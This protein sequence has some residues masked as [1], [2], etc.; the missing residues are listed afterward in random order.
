MAKQQPIYDARGE[1]ALMLELWDPHLAD[2]IHEFVR[3]VYPWGKPGTPLE[4]EKGPRNWQDKI[5][6]DMAEYIHKAKDHQQ[7]HKAVPAMY[8]AAIASGRGIGKSATFGWLAHWLVTTRIGGSV[9]V[10]ANGEP[11]LKTKTFPE[12]AKWVSMSINSHWFEIM[13]TKI[14][15][16][17]WLKSAVLRDLKIDA[18]YWYIA[19]Q[20]WSEE[21]PDAFA[22]AHN[23]Y[24]EMAL[25][26]E[27][28]GIPSPIWTVQQGVFTE[29]IVDRYWLAFSNPRRPS[30][31]FFECFHKNRDDW[32]GVQVDSRS[33]DIAQD[34]V[35]AIIKEHGEDSDEARIEVYGQFPS[36]GQNQFIGRSEVEMALARDIIADPGSPL[37]MG[38][39]VARF[40]EDTSV[41]AFRKGRDARTIPWHRYKGMS[42]TQLTGIVADLAGKMHV[43]AI[44]VD[45][46]GV[47]GG[48]VDQLK[49]LGYR[50]IEVQSG[51]SATNKDK[52]QNKRAEMWDRMKE[53]VTHGCL[54][55]LPGIVDD[56]CNLMY[57]YTLGN[58][59]KLERKDEL[60]KRG[61]ASPDLADA[62]AFTFAQ[63][64]A[65]TDERHS[66]GNSQRN[67]TARDV[68]YD[69]FASR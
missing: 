51:E 27:A 69:I 30:G 62:L 54:P 46:N 5:L 11:Q 8:K 48:V 23:A 18:E 64:V 25:F 58:Q 38:V 44:F 63:P 21:N 47:G 37:V 22:G 9:W 17:E 60:K 26:D 43:A 40:G 19:A 33:V 52:Y 66:R 65:R 1:Q 29:K 2:N 41:I 34:G 45:G 57:G 20:L 35:N 16:A 68:D 3:F 50:V 14:E 55:A 4:F 36:K 61:F 53:W 6:R 49:A 13:A 12:I 42:T 39:D 32:R 24:G 67:R 7:I 28:S 15:P 59:I 31:S 10:A 56:L